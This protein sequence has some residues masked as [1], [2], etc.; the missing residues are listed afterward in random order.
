MAR[1]LQVTSL[2][3]SF[4]SAPDPV[5]ALDAVSLSI[6]PGTTVAVMGPS[7]SGKSTLLAVIG[8]LLQPDTGEV[9][10]DGRTITALNGRERARYRRDAIGFVFQAHNLIPFLTAAENVQLPAELGPRAD[11][12]VSRDVD[13]LLDELGIADRADALASELSGG[14][15]QRV[16]IARALVRDPDLLL[17]DEPTANLDSDTGEQI[18]DALILEVRQRDKMGILV[19]HDAEMARRAD[20]VVS[21]HDGRLVRAS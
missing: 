15:R 2:S 10:L 5:Q 9:V 18:V 8:A 12:R 7:G 21:L 20:S 19:T 4:R 14:E 3:K 6:A 13:G 16:A 17:V 1:G 11:R